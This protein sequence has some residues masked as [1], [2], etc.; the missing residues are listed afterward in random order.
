MK[1]CSTWYK[2]I[3]ERSKGQ[4]PKSWILLGEKRSREE[5]ILHVNIVQDIIR[6]AMQSKHE[7]MLKAMP[8]P[9]LSWLSAEGGF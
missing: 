7:D 2:R 3:G 5:N 9:V 6:Q 8:F 1:D 4:D